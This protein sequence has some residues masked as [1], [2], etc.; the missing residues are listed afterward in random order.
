MSVR[1]A[2]SASCALA[3]LAGAAGAQEIPRG[4]VGC[5]GERLAGARHVLEGTVGQAAIGEAGDAG[6]VQ[7]AGYWY[8]PG[9]GVTAACLVFFA[10]ERAG[11]DVAVRWLLRSTSPEDL[12]HVWRA[13]PG[14]PRVRV[15]RLAVGGPG[16]CEFLDRDAPAGEL[17]YWLELDGADQAWFGPVRLPALPLRFE[18]ERN[19]P[20][21][22]NPRT[23]LRFSLPRAA[24]VRLEV[25][26][27]RGR[28]VRTLLTGRQPSGVHTVVWDG[29][30]EHGGDA[31][32]GVYVARLESSLGLVTRKMMLVR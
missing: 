8:L 32:S 26:D 10:V 24:T 14:Q 3:L 20:N 16:R 31:A 12:C 1:F 6:I 4:V 7:L 30:D 25:F 29:R 9:T 2:L 21:P 18:L 11:D 23:S 13:E 5:G 27:V 28:L 15:S 22:F 17:D 19:R